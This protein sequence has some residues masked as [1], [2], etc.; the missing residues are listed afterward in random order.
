[1][2]LAALRRGAARVVVEVDGE[3]LTAWYDP[4]AY[5]EDDEADLHQ[6]QGRLDA[7]A[8]PILARVIVAWDL[9]DD[10]DLVPPALE[11]L[12][13][14]PPAVRA[15][16]ADAILSDGLDE[17]P[18]R[19][20]RMALESGGK[21]GRVPDW[22][23]AIDDARWSG[24]RPWELQGMPDDVVTR[25]YWRRWVNWSHAA[26]VMATNVRSKRAA[27]RRDK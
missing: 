25:R 9:T 15:A 10:D 17:R 14:L 27:Q 6:L 3:T 22:Y 13:G 19:D 26:E 11:V 16:L 1:M 24:L 2:D 4:R 21:V 8:A 18:Y 20:L 23:V 5:T 7:V 12:I